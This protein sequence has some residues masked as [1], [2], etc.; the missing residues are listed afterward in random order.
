MLARLLVASLLVALAGCRPKEQPA[1]SSS[2]TEGTTTVPAKPA[3]PP[4]GPVEVREDKFPNGNVKSRAEGYR[5]SEGNFVRHGPATRF[6][7]NG[8]KLAEQHFNHGELHGAEAMWFIEGRLKNQGQY[9]N[10]L[11]D[12]KWVT[13]FD[14]GTPH[15][16][17]HMRM[18]AWHGPYIEWHSNG[19]KRLEVEF[20]DG[21]RQG[22]SITYDDQGVVAL[23]TDYVD[24]IE[25]P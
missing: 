20:V 18:G 17:W 15:T 12:G 13:F 24:G 3:S 23:R 7:E 11:E 19:K 10:G 8:R 22:P 1:G 4:A 5:D 25:Q 16:E 14:D 2:G 6:Y 9:V 21:K